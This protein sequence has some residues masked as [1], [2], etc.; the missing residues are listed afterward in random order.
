MEGIECQKQFV[1]LL[2]AVL[3]KNLTRC[4]IS[5]STAVPV[6]AATKSLDCQTACL[7]V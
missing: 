7:A 2:A 6:P 3:W 1:F 5:V 4:Q